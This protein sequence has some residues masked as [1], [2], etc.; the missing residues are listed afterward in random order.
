VHRASGGAR[1][2]LRRGLAAAALAVVLAATAA[3]AAVTVALTPQQQV[4]PGAE[5]DLYV[6]ITQAGAAFNGFEAVVGYDANALTFVQRSPL[7][8][9]EGSAITG[10]C[11]TTFHV[12]S[13]HAGVDSITDVLLCHDVTLTGPGQLYQLRFR[14]SNTVQRTTVTFVG[15]P[16]FYNGGLFVTPVTATEVAIGIGMPPTADVGPNAPRALTLRAVPDP[17]PGHLEFRIEAD[18]AGPAALAIVDV[19]GRVV[20]RLDAGT[21]APGTRVLPWDGRD[22]A[23]AR[24]PPGVYLAR[25]EVAGRVAWSRVTLLR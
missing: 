9:Q 18:R 14:A 17:A 25:L 11:G 15:T 13:A 24:L 12:F 1:R 22:A 10:A 16:R 19:Q 8:L 6:Q 20:R 7:S 21:L 23:G 2:A 5:F 3:G 4:S